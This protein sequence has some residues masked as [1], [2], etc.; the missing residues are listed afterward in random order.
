[1]IIMAAFKELAI[2]QYPHVGEK[3]TRDT[4]YW[5]NYEVNLVRPY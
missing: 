5:K 4:V 2:K 3:I 1:M